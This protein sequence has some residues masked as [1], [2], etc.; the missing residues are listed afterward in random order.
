[1]KKIV[2]GVEVDMSA[3][4]AAAVQA[5]WDAAAV[6]VHAPPEVTMRQARQALILAGKLATVNAALAGMTGTAGELARAEWEYS[7]AVQRHRP[8]VLSLG[9][10]LGMSSADLDAL[11]IQAASL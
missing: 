5:E 1:M 2:N 9:A 10:A 3:E 8:L 7:I 4:E 6:A 11:F